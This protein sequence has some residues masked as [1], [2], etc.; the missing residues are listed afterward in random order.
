MSTALAVVGDMEADVEENSFAEGVAE[1]DDA[2]VLLIKAARLSVIS[3]ENGGKMSCNSDT[4]PGL[5]W[6]LMRTVDKRRRFPLTKT[7]Y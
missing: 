1:R 5:T 6:F 4:L 3:L 7:T 2:A